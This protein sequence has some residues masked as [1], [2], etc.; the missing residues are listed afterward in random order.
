MS[1]AAQWLLPVLDSV[2]EGDY[3]TIPDFGGGISDMRAMDVSADGTIMVGYGNNKRGQIGF[4]ADMTDPLLPV[5]K[6]LTITDSVYTAQTL[7]WTVA[8]AV[9]ADGTDHRR[10]RRHEEGEPRLRHD[11]ARREH[12]PDHARERGPAQRSAAASTPRPMR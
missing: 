5:V 4:R 12:G 1:Y 7:K 3:V 2:D 10:L 9:S 6:T 8:E 11:G